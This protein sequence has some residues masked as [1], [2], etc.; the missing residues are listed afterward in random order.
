V[1]RA[2]GFLLGVFGV[3]LYNVNVGELGVWS[4]EFIL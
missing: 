1:E 2:W 4:L 3:I